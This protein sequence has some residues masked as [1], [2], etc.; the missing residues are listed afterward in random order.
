MRNSLIILYQISKHVTL[1]A[2][3]NTIIH[4]NDITICCVCYIKMPLPLS[5]SCFSKS[6]LVLSFWFY[7]SGAGSP[8]WSRTESKIAVKWWCVFVI[9]ASFHRA[10]PA[11]TQLPTEKF[12]I[13]A[14]CLFFTS[15]VLYPSCCPVSK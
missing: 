7:L 6:R 14:A 11:W 1:Y 5:I 3:N 15:Q 2:H 10:T 12:Q 9:P 13:T 8:G 4:L